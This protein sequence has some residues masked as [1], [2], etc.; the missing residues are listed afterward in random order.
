[1]I[2][3]VAARGSSFKGAG[4]YYLHD[5]S[6]QTSKRVEWALT[7]NVPTN[8]P[9]KA[10]K[11]MAY[12]SMNAEKIKQEYGGSRVGRKSKGKSVYTYSLSWHKDDQ[13]T[14]EEMQ[15]AAFETLDCLEL[16]D[17]EAVIVAHRDTDHPHVHVICNLVNPNTGRT[18]TAQLDQ[19]KLSEWAQEHD[20]RFGRDHCPERIKNNQERIKGQLKQE[21]TR[22]QDHKKREGKEGKTAQ[23]V[24]HRT[25]ADPRAMMIQ[26]LYNRSDSGKAFR[27]AL[28]EEGYDLAQGHK[29]RVAIV[30][31]Y[32]QVFSLSR[33]L[34]GQR[35]RDIKSRLSDVKY[36]S[37]PLAKDLADERMYFDRDRYAAEQ[38]DKI[39]AAAV[40]AEKKRLQDEKQQGEQQREDDKR[41]RRHQTHA[42]N[43]K[44][45]K[46]GEKSDVHEEFNEEV[47]NGPKPP[48][49]DKPDPQ[50]SKKP[51]IEYDDTHL[52]RLDQQLSWERSS[53][54]KRRA[55]ED[56]MEKQY[57]RKAM[58][59]Q[60][61]QLKNDMEKAG[62]LGKLFGRK[63]ALQEEYDSLEKDLANVDW[64]ISEYRETLER[65]IEAQKPEWMKEHEQEKDKGKTVEA[66]KKSV[67]TYTRNKTQDR[68]HDRDHENDLS[69]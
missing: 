22:Q 3:H 13:P 53:D 28:K 1:M 32:G 20:K 4:L 56:R 16:K 12:T 24:K 8:D 21:F 7:H 31:E 50:T 57:G 58:T 66:F 25:K 64:R 29:G 43:R 19:K 38:Q 36:R 54:R 67:N 41:K 40:A 34:K 27:S 69:L 48:A 65:E 44:P 33:Q 68:F 37:L 47:H 35:A 26:D 15:E 17:H 51:E 63:K 61:D 49:K 62:A 45:Y 46:V 52:I 42:K 9:E 39:D 60:L 14:R 23:F 11:W 5:K 18:H 59:R 10:L 55:F 6:A 2:P 30:N